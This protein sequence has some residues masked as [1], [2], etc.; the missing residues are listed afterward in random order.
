MGLRPPKV[1]KNAKDLGFVSGHGFSRAAQPPINLGLPRRSEHSPCGCVFRERNHGPFGP[2]KGMKNGLGL[3]SL[4]S[5][6]EAAY[7]SEHLRTA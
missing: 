6:A 1:M 4:P 7:L 2:P 5:A 3:K